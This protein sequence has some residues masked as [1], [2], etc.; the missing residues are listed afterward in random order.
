MATMSKGHSMEYAKE[1]LEIQAIVFF[2]VWVEDEDDPMEVAHAISK[3]G[4]STVVDQTRRVV[5]VFTAN[6]MPNGFGFL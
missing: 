3:L 6:P 5:K 2:E 1:M 4:C